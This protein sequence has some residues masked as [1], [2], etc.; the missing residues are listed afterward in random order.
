MQVSSN[1]RRQEKTVGVTYLYAF[2][3]M[4]AVLL[5][6]LWYFFVV[7]VHNYDT[8]AVHVDVITQVRR[9][10]ILLLF[11]SSILFTYLSS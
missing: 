3:R 5:S 7:T 10:Q 9:V 1:V 6:T 4:N 8:R 2:F 11:S